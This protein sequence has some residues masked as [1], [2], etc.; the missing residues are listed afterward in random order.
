MNADW[1]RWKCKLKK[2]V[3]VNLAR[4]ASDH[5][6]FLP[7]LELS[8]TKTNYARTTFRMTNKIILL[9]KNKLL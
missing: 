7:T 9:L 6:Y 4:T 5:G 1:I 3:I 2:N 8:F